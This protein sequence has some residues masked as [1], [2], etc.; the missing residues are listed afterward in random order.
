MMVHS[1]VSP[2]LHQPHN[3]AIRRVVSGV[4][5]LFLQ[6]VS[7][8]LLRRRSQSA[9]YNVCVCVCP[10]G[11]AVEPFQSIRPMKSGLYSDEVFV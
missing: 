10:L 4:G 11:G 1:S 2:T 7:E 3:P 9:R 8:L 6:Q 5:D